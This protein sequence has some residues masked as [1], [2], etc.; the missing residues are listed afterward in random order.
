MLGLAS[1]AC[2]ERAIEQGYVPAGTPAGTQT[3][4]ADRA[5]AGVSGPVSLVVLGEPGKHSRGAPVG[6]TAPAGAP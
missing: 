1:L 4:L 5:V 3:V 6:A 2:H